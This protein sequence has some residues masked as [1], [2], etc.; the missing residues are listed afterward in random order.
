MFVPFLIILLF[1]FQIYVYIF[2]L[3]VD[4]DCLS[5]IQKQSFV[6][7][8]VLKYLHMT[9]ILVVRWWVLSVRQR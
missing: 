2:F 5:A 8:L 7:D 6:T 3:T 1:F 9:L 4:L